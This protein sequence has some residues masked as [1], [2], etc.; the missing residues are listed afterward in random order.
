MGN[1]DHKALDGIP[2]GEFEPLTDDWSRHL[3]FVIRIL[4]YDFRQ[5]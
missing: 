2:F 5:E 3:R 1:Y 4:I